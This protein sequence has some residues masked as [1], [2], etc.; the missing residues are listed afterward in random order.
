L[1]FLSF[2][3]LMASNTFDINLVVFNNYICCFY[4]DF[5]FMFACFFHKMHEIWSV[6]SQENYKNC[7][8][9]MSDFKAKMHQIRFRVRVRPRPRW[10]SLQRS[11]DTL[12]GFKRPT[13]KGEGWE[14]KG[15]GMGRKG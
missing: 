5:R 10:G 15:R 9:Q 7:C 8:H 14:G 1:L 2:N 13:S 4:I 3:L 11:P 12:D 6:D